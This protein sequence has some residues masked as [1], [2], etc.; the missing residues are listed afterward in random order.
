V[1]PP[2]PKAPG[3]RPQ[4]P[5]RSSS[6]PAA[7]PRAHTP[8]P[9]VADK[10]SPALAHGVDSEDA[11]F[12]LFTTALSA[13]G[14]ADG[15][16]RSLL[17]QFVGPNLQAHW[18]DLHKVDPL[19]TLAQAVAESENLCALGDAWKGTKGDLVD[20][21]LALLARHGLYGSGSMAA[22]EFCELVIIALRT[23]R[24]MHAPE[25]F[26]RDLRTLQSGTP[27]LKARY[28]DFEFLSRGA[29]GKT[30]K[31][32]SRLTREER[33]CRQTRKDR[34][35]ASVDQVRVEVELL[36]TL[37]HPHMPRIV[38]HFEDFNSVYIIAEFVEGIELMA[39]LQEPSAMRGLSESW[40][41]EVVRQTLEVLR[42]CH[43]ARPRRVV[44]GDLRLESILLSTS[45]LASP[46]VVVADLGL[47]GLLP[48][49]KTLSATRAKADVTESVSS[50]RDIW[51]CGCILFLFLAGKH[52]CGDDLMSPLLPSCVMTDWTD[53][54]SSSAVSLCQQMLNPDVRN[55]SSAVDALRHP[56]LSSA[57]KDPLPV[58]VLNSL[59]QLH[60]RS[61]FRQV[62]M[63]LA[64]SELGTAAFSR[65][66]ATF[67]ALDGRGDGAVTVEAASGALLSLGLSEL[68]VDKV[69]CAYE[70]GG[71]GMMAYHGFVGGCAE[72]AE[73][74][75]DH[76]LWRVFTVVGED[77]RGV[78]GAAELERV[79]DGCAGV[80]EACDSFGG[81]ERY[82]RAALDPELTA[83]EI[84]RQI[85]CGGCEVTFE[86]LKDFVIRR[87][88]ATA[89][90]LAGTAADAQGLAK[91]G[92]RRE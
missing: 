16:L 35:H 70:L 90:L 18:S 42:H 2:E 9:A 22:E 28:A 13:P 1:S 38:E 60:A 24:D 58:S 87:Q 7:L 68:S 85:A 61:R 48:A 11:L 19:Q 80:G 74:R 86:A 34:V 20:W 12:M 91:H 77:H 32:R 51:S 41:A 33:A 46:H 52:P 88:D 76:A 36:R 50:K 15:A 55:R 78:L 81:S 4:T 8:G 63:N 3:E 44:H 54:H 82:I 26:L 64:V 21:W 31:C 39:F 69:L 89:A 66:G 45:D 47:A 27:R 79:L 17:S 56:W 65:L 10:M 83:S 92:A 14:A 40:L 75:L 53:L 73:D 25:A 67:E 57:P 49:P 23:L 37:E 59:V 84:V 72:L 71:T 5:G 30:Y 29:L 6:P 62:V 43:E